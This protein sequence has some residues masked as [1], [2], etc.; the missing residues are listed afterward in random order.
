MRCFVYYEHDIWAAANI[1]IKRYG[2]YA[3]I[4]ADVRH[5][6]VQ[7]KGDLEELEIWKQII[8]AIQQLLPDVA[9]EDVTL[10]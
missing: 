9:P 7:T 8:G 2:E 3:E 10:H 5:E 4:I 6:R 1:L